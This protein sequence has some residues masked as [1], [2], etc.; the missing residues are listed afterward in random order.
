MM[1]NTKLNNYIQENDSLELIDD[2]LLAEIISENQEEFSKIQNLREDIL[3]DNYI[4]DD[5]DYF[6]NIPS[7]TKDS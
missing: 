2:E 5:L 6:I 3:L 4:E 1:D 7:D